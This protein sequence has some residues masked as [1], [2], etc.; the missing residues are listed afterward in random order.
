MFIIAVIVNCVQIDHNWS[1]AIDKFA[2][3]CIANELNLNG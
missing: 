2:Y 1:C 3:L